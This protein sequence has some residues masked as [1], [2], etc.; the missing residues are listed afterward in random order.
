VSAYFSVDDLFTARLGFDLAGAVLL[1]IGLLAPAS[2]IVQRG[3]P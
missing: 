3:A 1:G 2:E